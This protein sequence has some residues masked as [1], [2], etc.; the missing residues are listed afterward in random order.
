[1]SALDWDFKSTFKGAFF[2]ADTKPPPMAVVIVF[3]VSANQAY[4]S[5]LLIAQLRKAFL[6][7]GL[8]CSNQYLSMLSASG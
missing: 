5:M 2:M 6:L 8:A 4:L 1:M 7:S 3:S